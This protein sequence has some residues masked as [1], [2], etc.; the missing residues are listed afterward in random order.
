MGPAHGKTGNFKSCTN[1]V[2]D[3]NITFLN[4][5][6]V[7]DDSM[8]LVLGSYIVFARDFTIRICNF[9]MLKFVNKVELTMIVW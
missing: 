1:P 4:R 5:L 9:Q 3:T 8:D 6:D 7:A 2:F